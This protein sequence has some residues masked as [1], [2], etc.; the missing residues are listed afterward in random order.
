[1]NVDWKSSY[2]THNYGEIFYALMR[3]YRPKKVVELGTKAGYSAYHMARGMRENGKGSLDCYDLWDQYPFNS[4]PDSEVATN[5]QDFTDILQLHKADAQVVAA[6]YES[7]DVLHVD[8]SNDGALLNKILPA[9]ISKVRQLI[10]IEGGS[11]ERDS[12]DWMKKFHKEPIAPWLKTFCAQHKMEFV[13]ID[14]F[15]SITLIKP[16]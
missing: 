11:F 10:I 6:L 3:V 9:W 15:P 4:V 5:L 12:I 14:P 7:V 13:T 1:M 8:L 2:E 16:S